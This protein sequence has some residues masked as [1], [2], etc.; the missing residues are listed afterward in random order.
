MLLQH[1]ADSDGAP[2]AWGQGK[3]L[4]RTQDKLGRPSALTYKIDTRQI[5]SNNIV[6]MYGREY[7]YECECEWEWESKIKRP[8]GIMER[9]VH[10]AINNGKC[11]GE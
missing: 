4:V 11:G 10:T 5:R 7:E 9:S 3:D 1:G 6:D 2:G 8:S